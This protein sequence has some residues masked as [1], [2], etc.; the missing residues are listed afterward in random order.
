MSGDQESASKKLK[1]EE[2][3]LGDNLH[4]AID[5]CFKDDKDDLKKVYIFS[6]FSISFNVI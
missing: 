4:F 3:S 1:Q 2:K 6:V 5:K